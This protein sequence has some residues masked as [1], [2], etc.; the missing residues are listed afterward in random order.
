MIS[1]ESSKYNNWRFLALAVVFG[2]GMMISLAP[3][4]TRADQQPS[5]M[6]VGY[7]SGTIT[8]IYEVTFQIDH[9]TYS[10]TPDAVLLDRHGDELDAS[11]LR[12]DIEVKYHLQKDSKDKIDRMILILPQ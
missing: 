2:I 6:T 7:Q 3:G 1:A 9:R 8:G 12:M 10:L 11:Y 5:V 4:M